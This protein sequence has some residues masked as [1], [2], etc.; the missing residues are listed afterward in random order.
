MSEQ[1]FP[2]PSSVCDTGGGQ[3][4]AL[5]NLQLGFAGIMQNLVPFTGH[6]DAVAE[7]EGVPVPRSGR[8]IEI[9][10]G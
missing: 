2:V 6:S 7:G 8:F 5:D 9:S 1:E 3:S 4:G 10:T